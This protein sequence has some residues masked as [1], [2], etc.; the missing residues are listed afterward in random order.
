MVLVKIE[1]LSKTF[2]QN[3]T[4]IYALKDLMLT[5]NR[6]E[7]VVFMGPSGAG[8]STLLHVITGL[9]SPTKG[10]IF[11]EDKN[12]DAMS[13][14]EK[15]DLRRE[16]FGII[17]Q[18][19]NLHP[20]LTVAENIELPLMILGVPKSQR[21]KR[22][23]NALELVA[24]SKR[25]NHYPKE[26]S[27]GE[28]Q[29]IAIARA[30]IMN[31]KILI[32]DEPTGNLDYEN[33]QKIIELLHTLQEKKQLTVIQVTHDASMVHLGDRLIQ[34]EDGKIINDQLI[35]NIEK[36]PNYDFYHI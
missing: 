28:Q 31:P 32:A 33:S 24:M 4:L 35:D 8:K 34:M 23:E 12:L 20:Q 5:I 30:L 6:G 11:I 19:F 2:G 22:I 18:F 10:I 36:V 17:L 16:K 3:E 26:I 27:V 21:K 15:C 1:N 29:R 7:Y 25:R 9:E 14:A 13:D